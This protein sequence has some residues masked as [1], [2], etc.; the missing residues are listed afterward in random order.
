MSNEELLKNQRIIKLLAGMLG[1]ALLVLFGA[2]LYI[3][4]TKGFSPL[5]ITSV[6]LMPILIININNLNEIKK[7]IKARNL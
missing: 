3:T 1:G 5:F 6:A 4:F 7:E 2:G